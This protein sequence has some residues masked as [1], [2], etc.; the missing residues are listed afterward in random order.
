MNRYG[1]DEIRHGRWSPLPRLLLTI[2]LLLPLTACIVPPGGST[3]TTVPTQ[4]TESEQGT[5]GACGQERWPVK[6]MSD[7]M[8]SQVD[9]TP[10]D[11][12]VSDLTSLRAPKALP[13]NGRV[14][15]T[16]LNTYRLTARLVEAKLEADNDVHL[17]IAD[18]K[19]TNDTMIV[20]IP[21]PAC[22]AVSKSR[23]QQQISTVRQE[24]VGRFGTPPTTHFEHI[25]GTARITGIGFFDFQHGQT[26]VAPNAIELHPVIDL[27]MLGGG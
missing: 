13:Q 17:V 1:H 14:V 15:P 25:S 9:L 21:S 3:S 5:N 23:V 6:T 16:E 11:T 2:V 22:P 24:F 27:Q 8:A 12:T 26:G 20:E 4:E 18:P 10:I 19:N 7:S